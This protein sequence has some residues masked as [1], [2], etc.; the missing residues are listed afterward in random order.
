MKTE[1]TTINNNII[2]SGSKTQLSSLPIYIFSAITFLSVVLGGDFG[3]G[4]IL[5]TLLL[6]LISGYKYLK[7]K[8]TKYTI[9]SE[10]ATLKYGILST[11]TEVLELFKVKDLSLS[12]PILFRIFGLSTIEITS[13][14]PSHPHFRIVGLRDGEIVLKDIKTAVANS[15]LKNNVMNTFLH[16]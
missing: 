7:N 5:V 13:T 4:F 11:R 15:R 9:D 3:V 16:K 1:Q 14:D 8:L 12:Q 2:Y 10:E 6:L